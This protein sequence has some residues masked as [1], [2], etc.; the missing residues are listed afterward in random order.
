[1]QQGLSSS[2]L[3]LTLTPR[4]KITKLRACC[5]LQNHTHAVWFGTRALISV[6]AVRNHFNTSWVVCLRL[7]WQW[8][9]CKVVLLGRVS[10]IL[11]MVTTTTTTAALLRQTTLLCFVSGHVSPWLFSMIQ[12]KRTLNVLLMMKCAGFT[13]WTPSGSSFRTVTWL[14][15]VMASS[16]WQ[17]HTAKSNSRIQ[18][19]ILKKE[20]I[21]Q[22]I[23]C[24]TPPFWIK[25]PC[26]N[27]KHNRLDLF[28]SVNLFLFWNW[29]HCNLELQRIM[30]QLGHRTWFFTH[31]N[32]RTTWT[33]ALFARLLEAFWKAY[34]D[35][36][37][38]SWS[39]VTWHLQ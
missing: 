20:S 33:L 4:F 31:G 29:E 2:Q 3:A 1:M 12:P 25:T 26:E 9:G 36:S 18:D 34:L 6:E 39:S 5:F 23:K 14:A 10:S 7:H 38:T 17:L 35:I 13:G 32:G 30:E 21:S 27:E 11:M 28:L 16:P 37:S 8:H 22:Q 24:Q 15:G 19:S